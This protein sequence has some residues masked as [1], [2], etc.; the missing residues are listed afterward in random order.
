MQRPLELV[1]LAEAGSLGL[2]QH[3]GN[4]RSGACIESLC[5]KLL[6]SSESVVHMAVP[7]FS[8]LNT[9]ACIPL[10]QN[11]IRLGNSNTKYQQPN[12]PGNSGLYDPTEVHTR[13]NLRASIKESLGGL[14]PS[15]YNRSAIPLLSLH[16]LPHALLLHLHVASNQQSHK[17]SN[18]SN[19]SSRNAIVKVY[20]F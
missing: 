9:L 20:P 11:P 10:L 6:L 3:L 15:F 16:G 13:S 19:S 4:Q 17:Q 12:F 14:L 5:T 2:A 7:I 18:K 1:H 8:P